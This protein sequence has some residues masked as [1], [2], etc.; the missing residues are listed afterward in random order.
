MSTFLPGDPT[1]ISSLDQLEAF[2]ER[3]GRRRGRLGM[4]LE[5]LPLDARAHLV[6]YAGSRGVEAA[7]KAACD[8][9][10]PVVEGGHVIALLLAK[11]G[12]VSLEPGGQVEVDSPP[13]ERIEGL[14]TF[15]EAT[16]RHLSE[17]ARKCGFGLYPWGM[18]PYGSTEDLPDVPKARYRLLKA[19]LQESGR[20]GRW[21]MKLTAAGHFCLDYEDEADMRRKV[22]AAIRLLPYAVAFTA[23]APVSSGRRH[24]WLTRRP[25]VW[26]H[27]DRLRCG[28]PSFLFSPE[29]GFRRYVRYALTR[30]LLF[31]VRDGRYVPGRGRTFLEWLRRPGAAGPLTMGDWDLHLSTLF[32]DLRLR[33]GY[34]EIRTLDALPLPFFLALGAFFKGLLAEPA[35][36]R[37]VAGGGPE[38][39]PADARRFLLEAARRGPEWAPQGAPAPR[40]HVPVL[41]R[42]ARRGL[43]ELGED[44]RWLDPLESLVR[45]RTCPALSWKR[46]AGGVWRGPDLFDV[47]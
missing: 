13:A 37:H 12:M 21:M 1:E 47:G 29:L 31:I 34:L 5:L 22:A 42:L 15:F 3:G 18:A 10:K 26:R 44:P 28:L 41:L 25:Q 32:P 43:R 7:L 40:E 6:P 2:F 23:N 46:D 27:T 9:C 8:R 30:P 39:T 4:E 35:V 33:A 24:G 19:H 11:G 36:L 16:L 14:S 20:L 38:L 45:R 17:S